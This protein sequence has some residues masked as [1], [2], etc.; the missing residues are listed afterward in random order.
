MRLLLA[1]FALMAVTPPC[2]SQRA[3]QRRAEISAKAD[4]LFGERYVSPQPIRFDPERYSAPRDAV[5]W[6]HGAQFVVELF[7]ADDKSI[8]ALAVKPIWQLYGDSMPD[9]A[10]HISLPPSELQTFLA[11]A[12]QLRPL[13]T[14]AAE[15]PHDLCFVSGANNYCAS[16]YEFARVSYYV[17][18]EEPSDRLTQSI[19]IGY[20]RNITG[21]VDKTRPEKE[22]NN[23][24]DVLIA[25][26]WYGMENSEF[27]KLKMSI[28][29]HHPVALSTFGCVPA[30]LVCGSQIYR[31]GS[32]KIH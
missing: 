11:Q 18:E 13:G 17:R 22:S 28:A 5:R 21:T 23:R 3:A 29:N 8:A 20:R 4:A 31:A 26:R 2:F 12:A 9:E 24:T 7:F 30:E 1:A 27:A 19:W 14:L 25:G 6:L 10:R 15:G 32:Q 16:L